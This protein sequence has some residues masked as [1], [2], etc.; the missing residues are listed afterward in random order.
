MKPWFSNFGSRASLKLS[1]SSKL[2]EG[3]YVEA[4]KSAKSFLFSG[5]ETACTS[6]PFNF[7]AKFFLFEDLKY[8]ERAIMNLK[9]IWSR[10]FCLLRPFVW[11]LGVVQGMREEFYGTIFVWFSYICEMSRGKSKEIRM[12]DVSFVWA[13]SFVEIPL[14][15]NTGYLQPHLRLTSK[16]NRRE[17]AL[18]IFL[19]FSKSAP[20]KL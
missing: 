3:G 10:G 19:V 9:L 13:R 15:V 6:I 5:S 1:G 2:Y 4:K 11:F 12:I 8:L 7:D 14:S 18:V 16:K 20:Q 17:F